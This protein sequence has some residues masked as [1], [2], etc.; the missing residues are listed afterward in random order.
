MGQDIGSLGLDVQCILPNSPF[1]NCLQI[2]EAAAS[3][4]VQQ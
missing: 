2:A 3:F 4:L 1:T